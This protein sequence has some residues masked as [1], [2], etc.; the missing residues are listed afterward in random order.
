MEP[1]LIVKQ[2]YKSYKLDNREIEVLCGVNLVINKGEFIAIKG[3]SGAGKST[4]LH[5][6]GSLDL[7]DKGEIL[8]DSKSLFELNG[9]SLCR[10]RNKNVGFIFQAYHLLPELTAIENVMLPARL[11]RINPVSA[12]K[13]AKILLSEVGLGERLNHRPRELSGGEQ[14]RVAIAR[15]M[16]NKPALILADEPTGNLDS[17]NG[18]EI[19][20]LLSKIR[21][22]NNTTLI[23]ATHDSRIAE[24]A[25]RQV[26]IVDGKINSNNS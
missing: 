20:N 12:E 13:S 17:R 14:Q 1:F 15:A 21:S 10:W 23:I 11:S 5:L 3:A 7:P 19:I 18:D 16:I 22:E 4:L 2:L 26:E 6:L 24:K 25:E 8:Y 9:S